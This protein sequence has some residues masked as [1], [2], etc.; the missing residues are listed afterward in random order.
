MGVNNI[1]AD[2]STRIQ[3]VLGLR[4]CGDERTGQRAAER[5]DGRR[6]GARGARNEQ[7]ARHAGDCP[8]EPE[9]QRVVGHIA[10]ERRLESRV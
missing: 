6:V 7:R 8:K 3:H 4:E 2:L 5:C 9:V 10:S 1:G